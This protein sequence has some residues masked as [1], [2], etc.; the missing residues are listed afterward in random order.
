M[1]ELQSGVAAG[2]RRGLC[3]G[4]RGAELCWMQLQLSVPGSFRRWCGEVMF[5]GIFWGGDLV[6]SVIPCRGRGTGKIYPRK[7]PQGQGVGDL[8]QTEGKMFSRSWRG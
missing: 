5:L 6:E 4:G 3:L 1:G 2:S 7:R 8:R